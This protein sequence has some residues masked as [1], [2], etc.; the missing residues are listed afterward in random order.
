MHLDWFSC[1]GL[2]FHTR[3]VNLVPFVILS[4][5]GAMLLCW[6][7][8]TVSRWGCDVHCF[9]SLILGQLGLVL[10]GLGLCWTCTS[11]DYI[12]LG[13]RFDSKELAHLKFRTG[14]GTERMS[15][16][17]TENH[18]SS[19]AMKK[20]YKLIVTKY[21]Y[22]FNPLSISQIHYPLVECSWVRTIREPE[23]IQSNFF[24]NF[25]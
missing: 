10:L 9:L 21:L 6:L 11:L 20:R 1:L 25:I 18:R 19:N 3:D 17:E 13:T 4:G 12:G 22:F 7:G 15:K 2:T 16:N 23:P 14:W 24:W 8:L 5:L